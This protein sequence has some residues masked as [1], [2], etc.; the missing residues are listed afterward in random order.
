MNF[1]RMNGIGMMID[2]WELRRRESNSRLWLIWYDD[3]G[4]GGLGLNIARL[5][6]LVAL[7]SWEGKMKIIYEWVK[8]SVITL[9]EFKSLIVQFGDEHDR[10]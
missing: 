6:K 4:P 2:E 10:A 8:T 7:D 5:H 1:S 3:F 9:E